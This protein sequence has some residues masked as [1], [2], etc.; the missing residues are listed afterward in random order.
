MAQDHVDFGSV[1]IEDAEG[2][3]VGIIT[4]QHEL[5][6][7]L[8]VAITPIL[9]IAT[10]DNPMMSLKGEPEITSWL[11]SKRTELETSPRSRE[12]PYRYLDEAADKRENP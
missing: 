7:K 1:Q 8:D 11:L 4:I 12:H 10:E 3:V 2:N 5:L 6:D 9:A